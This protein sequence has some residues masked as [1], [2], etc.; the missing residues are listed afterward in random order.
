[1][2]IACPDEIAYRIVYI[3]YEQLSALIELAGVA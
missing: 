1:M 3:D 2:M